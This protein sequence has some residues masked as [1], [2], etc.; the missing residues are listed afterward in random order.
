MNIGIYGCGNFGFALAYHVGNIET[1][2]NVAIYDHS[3]ET[4]KNLREQRKNLSVSKSKK[5]NKKVIIYE[6]KKEFIKRT[7]VLIL[8]IPSKAL[9][10]VIYEIEPWLKKG[11]II[12]NT[13]KALDSYTGNV[14]SKSFKTIMIPCR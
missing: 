2:Q 12:L 7:D 6:N 3:N 1:N 5:L 10:K 14:M 4:T 9:R 13:A 11:V 8:T